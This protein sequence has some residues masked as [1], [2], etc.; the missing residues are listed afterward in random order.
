M[1]VTR[2][3]VI[4]RREGGRFLASCSSRETSVFPAHIVRRLANTS[5][6]IIW[7]DC[8]ICGNK[9]L[10]RHFKFV[11]NSSEIGSSPRP[12][13]VFRAFDR[14]LLV[15]VS[16]IRIYF[17]GASDM[18]IKPFF[19]RLSLALL[20][21]FS[22]VASPVAGQEVPEELQ[23][24]FNEGQMLLQE[25][26]VADAVELYRGITESNEDVKL[27]WFFL[28]YALHMNGELDEALKIHEKVA[29][30]EDFEPFSNIATYNVACVHALQH[31]SD[32]AIAALQKAIDKGF[33]RID[34]LRNDEDL[35]SLHTDV[36]FAGIMANLSGKTEM[37]GQLDKAEDLIGNGDFAG[38]AEIYKALLENDKRNDFVTYRLG[39]TLH[40][41]GDL[42]AALEMH[43]KAA[44]LVAVAPLANYNI[45]CVHSLKDDKDQAL[46][47]LEKAVDL[48]F[49]RLD[50]YHNDPDLENVRSDERFKALV[51][52]IEEMHD[53]SHGDHQHGEHSHDSDDHD[54]GKKQ[55]KNGDG[56]SL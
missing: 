19:I 36:R 37:V 35:Y 10:A 46:T 24:K 25:E 56:S 16:I 20:F 33:D 55:D 22:L 54:G 52:K 8:A 44:R 17:L 39:Y 50:A 43:T 12:Y 1:G 23:D 28:G 13:E 15:S 51:S 27:G 29:A 49:V 53:H 5:S 31:N 4:W 41:A 34:Q 47:F 48:G 14:T 9:V 6:R 7:Q 18:S 38:A 42:E 30:F 21:L 3:I 11:V 2:Y 26:Q 32:G 40:G 45:A